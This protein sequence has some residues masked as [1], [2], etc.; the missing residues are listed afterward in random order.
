[1][2][3]HPKFE[4]PYEIG[5]VI[6]PGLPILPET[7]ERHP[8][9]ALGSLAVEIDAGDEIAVLDPEGLQPAE[10]V[11][12]DAERPVEGRECSAQMPRVRPMACRRLLAAAG[13]SA[14]KMRKA[15]DTRGL[16]LGRAE[17]V[18]AFADGSRAGDMATFHAETDG[19]ADCRRARFARMASP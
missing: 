6:V 13:A 7:V 19:H 15:L 17:A 5:G 18:R 3:L 8:I 4:T 2:G 9:L 16:D 10:L 11:F 1:M 14:R 12:F